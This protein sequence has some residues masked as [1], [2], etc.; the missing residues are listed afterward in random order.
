MPAHPSTPARLWFGA[1]AG[2]PI[3]DAVPYTVLVQYRAESPG[4]RTQPS[5]VHARNVTL[6][7]AAAR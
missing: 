1:Y 5:P 4:A 7:T 6:S 3:R 2:F